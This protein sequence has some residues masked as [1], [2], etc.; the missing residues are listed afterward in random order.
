MG[1]VSIVPRQPQGLAILAGTLVVEAHRFG[2][3][4][5]LVH[6]GLATSDIEADVRSSRLRVVAHLLMLT[7]EWTSTTASSGLA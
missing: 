1:S 7:R 4:D 3:G 5:H 2:V 6:R